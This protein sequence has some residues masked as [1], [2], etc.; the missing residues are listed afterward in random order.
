MKNIKCVIGNAW[1]TFLFVDASALWSHMGRNV[2]AS[3]SEK[4]YFHKWS[5][6]KA[7]QYIAHFPELWSPLLQEKVQR[8]WGKVQSSIIYWTFATTI[9]SSF[10]FDQGQIWII[11][12]FGEIYN[13]KK[14]VKC[15]YDLGWLVKYTI[16]TVKFW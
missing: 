10:R 16:Q 11:F 14:L 9:I 1:Y 2:L 13:C 12:L 4:G 15:T 3:E 5:F 8:A 6:A 7:M